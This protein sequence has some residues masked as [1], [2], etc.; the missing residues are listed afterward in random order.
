MGETF[1]KPLTRMRTYLSAMD[2][3]A[4]LNPPPVPFPRVLAAIGPKMLELSRD[5]ADGAHPFFMP[6]EHTASARE[7]LGPGKLLIPHQTVLLESD[8][9]TAR[10]RGREIL[11]RVLTQGA[12]AYAKAWR[13]FGYH[14]D[15]ATISDRFVDATIAWGDAEA[16]AKRVREHLDAGAD[17]VLVSPAAPDLPGVVDELE[18]LA[19]TLGCVPQ[20]GRSRAER[21][22]R[23]E[24]GTNGH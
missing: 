1:D 17:H 9:G 18:R 11:R 24:T 23:P 15:G 3:E 13:G 16:I 19:P 8:P 20:A 2:E 12:S 6:V 5:A 4:G 14:E 10:E 22:A 21:H 7:I